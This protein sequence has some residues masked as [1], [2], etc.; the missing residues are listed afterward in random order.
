[1]T[2]EPGRHGRIVTFYSYKGGVGRTMALVNIGWILASNGLRV[3]VADWDLEA[4][5]LHRY[6][7]PLLIDP[8]LR[9]TGGIL[10][11]C[12]SYAREA[13]RPAAAGEATDDDW[14]R[15]C[16]RPAPY[17]TGTDLSFPG[18]G[19]LDL[20]PA[21]RQNVTYSAAISSF[22]WH[23]FYEVLGGGTF[24]Q[25]LR[26]ELIAAYDYVLIDSR[27][28]SSDTATMCTVVLPDVLLACFV[29][30]QQSMRGTADAAFTVNRAAPRPVHVLPVPMRV[31]AV[32][33]E[34]LEAA[35]D[36]ARAHFGPCLAWLPEESHHRYWGDVE[37]PYRP[38]YA[39]EEIPAVVA[40]RPDQ[41]HTLL[42]AFERLTGW[43]TTGL[44]RSVPPLPA[45]ERH[46]L[47]QAYARA[48]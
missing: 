8:E 21:G 39:Y 40:D 18:G 29:L 42:A 19:R 34:R 26:E 7:R 23:H 33:T 13:L 10:E 38:Y 9:F 27:S 3:L 30:N 17:I 47:R 20:M 35:R 5:G 15:A 31:E 46:R 44:V 32:E 45:A 4:P 41:P 24:L 11:L 2:S 48:D 1:M 12:Q 25:A 14:L 28:G 16:A 6:L 37:I 36:F 43:L 22:N